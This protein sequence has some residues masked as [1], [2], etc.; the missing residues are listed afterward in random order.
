LIQKEDGDHK[1]RD[2]HHDPHHYDTSDIVRI[3]GLDRHTVYQLHK[4]L[5][6]GESLKDLKLTTEA[7]RTAFKDNPKMTMTETTAS[8][9]VKVARGKSKRCLERPLLT[10]RQQPWMEVNM[11]FRTKDFWTQQSS[12]LNSLD[13]S[14]WWQVESKAYRVRHVNARD[15]KASFDKEWDA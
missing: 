3:L 2:R 9:A 15:L 10:Q 8:N 6:D 11:N 4:R 13:Y 5:N 1:A 7:A 12:D 14:V